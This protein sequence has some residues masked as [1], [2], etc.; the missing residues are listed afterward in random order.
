MSVSIVH[1]SE[2]IR[3][4]TSFGQCKRWMLLSDNVDFFFVKYLSSISTVCCWHFCKPK[5]FFLATFYFLSFKP[6]GE[7]FTILAKF[8]FLVLSLAFLTHGL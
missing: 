5:S 8:S 2:I 6:S 3:G 4:K 7:H 1:M